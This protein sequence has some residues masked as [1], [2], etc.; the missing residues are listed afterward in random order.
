MDEKGR[1]RKGFLTGAAAGI[2]LAGCIFLTWNFINQNQAVSQAHIRKLQTLERT[3]DQQYLGEI[4]KSQMADGMYLG[5][6]AGLADPYSRYYTPEQYQE[7]KEELEGAYQGI[8]ALLQLTDDGQITVV[9]CYEGYPADEAGIMPGD[10]L[11]KVN[12]KDLQD[13]DLENVTSMIKN[14]K[15][16]R[17]VL[18][19]HREGEEA[20]LDFEVSIKQ[21]EPR[22]VFHKILSKHTGYIRINTFNQQTLPQYEKAMKELQ[23]QGIKNLIVDLRENPGGLLN[24]V[25][26]ILN[27]ILPQ[28]LI[29][30]TEDKYGNREE[31]KST[32]EQ[33]L[34][35][36]LAVLVNENS[37]SASEIFAGA[38]QDH[39]MGTIIG[40]VTFGKGIVQSTCAFS[41]GS[42]LKLT[43]S[44]YYTPN[45]NDIHEVGIQPDITAEL[46]QKAKEKLTAGQ[47]LTLSEDTQ[48]AKALEIL[49]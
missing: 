34:S 20:L 49:N 36:P 22:T 7:T 41:D 17:A 47:E 24:T 32:G 10:I 11:V 28:G 44:H 14:S 21:V 9:Q 43:T 8:G 31:I 1:F 12:G 30:Y 35:L 40:T 33:T 13:I 5:L 38:V 25:C 42:A 45:G 4:D 19:I 2:L 37:A 3:I 27:D 29:V 6:V 18:T 23:A 16:G 39:K 26:D 15:G 46:S 48:L